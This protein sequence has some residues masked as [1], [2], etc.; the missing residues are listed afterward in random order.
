MQLYRTL[1]L[2]GCV[3][4]FRLAVVTEFRRF[5]NV[6]EISPSKIV[7]LQPRYVIFHN[8]NNM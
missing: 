4:F 1:S 7:F 8:L 2:S 3:G 6:K 5:F